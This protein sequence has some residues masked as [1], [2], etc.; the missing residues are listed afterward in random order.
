MIVVSR[1]VRFN[2][3]KAMWVSLEREIELNTDEEISAPK[4]EESQIDVEHS[5]VEDLGVETSTQVESSREG[6]KC[7]REAKILWDDAR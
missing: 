4:V 7:T 1:D 2:E 6:R 5:H 3:E